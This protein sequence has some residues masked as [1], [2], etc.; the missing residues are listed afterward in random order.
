MAR[1][2]DKHQKAELAEFLDLL[3]RMGGYTSQAQWAREAGFHQ[4]NLS[5]AM[6]RKTDAGLD[7]YSLLRLVRAVAERTPLSPEETVVRLAREADVGGAGPDVG[8]R[9]SE[10]EATVAAQGE[11]TTKALKALTAEIRRQ[12]RQQAAEAQSATQG[13]Q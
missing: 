6:S 2:L 13:A 10:V 3:Y 4:V 7:A 11:A 12:G 5:N 9:L 8:R 1:G